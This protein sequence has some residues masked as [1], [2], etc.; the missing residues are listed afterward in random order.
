[1]Y[2]FSEY[3]FSVQDVLALGGH[4]NHTVLADKAS[5]FCSQRWSAIQVFIYSTYIDVCSYFKM[6][7]RRK[8]YP[9]ADDERLRSQCFK[10]AWVTAVLH[11]GFNIDKKKNHF[12]VCLKYVYV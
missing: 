7:A 10:S 1:M 12:Q 6:A 3:W 8:L 4:Y 5:H 9:K 11:H 2:G